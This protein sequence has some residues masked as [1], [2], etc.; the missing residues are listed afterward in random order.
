MFKNLIFL[1]LMFI[2]GSINAA[3][4][5]NAVFAMGCFWCA[6][7]DFDKVYFHKFTLRQRNKEIQALVK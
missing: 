6:Q 7:S 5:Q 4:P 1:G 2:F 3:T